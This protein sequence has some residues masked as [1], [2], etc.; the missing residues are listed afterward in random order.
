[1]RPDTA[2]MHQEEHQATIEAVKEMVRPVGPK[3]AYGELRKPTAFVFFNMGL[4]FS[5]TL[6]PAV[7]RTS[8]V[9]STG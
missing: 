8:T 3:P 6:S 2:T 5:S 1:M 9:P 7:I 4:A